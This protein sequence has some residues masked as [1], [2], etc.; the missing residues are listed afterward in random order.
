RVSSF[1]PGRPAVRYQAAEE[2]RLVAVGCVSVPAVE[3]AG[4]RRQI[5]GGPLRDVRGQRL[6]NDR[7]GRPAL[8]SRVELQVPLERF[9]NE[10][11]RAFHMTYDSICYRRPATICPSG[12]PRAA[13]C[14]CASTASSRD[15]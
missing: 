6:A 9:R 15:T 5:R 3:C 7:G 1:R 13:A 2:Q 8:A 10:D 4:E 12:Y 11:R 14:R